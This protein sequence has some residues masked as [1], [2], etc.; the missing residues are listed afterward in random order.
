MMRPSCDLAI[1]HI[2]YV[3]NL[4]IYV[5]QRQRLVVMCFEKKKRQYEN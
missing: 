3:Y 4:V 1:L 2:D 5:N